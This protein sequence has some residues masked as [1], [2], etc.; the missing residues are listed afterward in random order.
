M[1]IIHF[2]YKNDLLFLLLVLVRPLGTSHA[3][4]FQDMWK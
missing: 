1:F 4:N 2:L 3:C